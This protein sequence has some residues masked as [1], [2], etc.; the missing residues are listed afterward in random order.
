MAI[1][2]K[3]ST[4]ERFDDPSQIRTM[5][6]SHEVVYEQWDIS[7]L[8]STPKHDGESDQDHVL[9]AFSDE[10]ERISKE[11]G[12]Q[13]ADVISLWPDT[14]NLDEVLARF[15]K[16]HFHTEDEVRF[17]VS[18]RGIFAIRGLDGEM[19][20][21]EVQPGDLLAVPEGK[22]HYFEL[23]DD[24]HI[25]CIRL[26]TDQAGWVAHYIEESDSKG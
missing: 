15:D 21:V 13:S 12:Y 3:Q 6:E 2:T 8:A 26:F 7:R 17:V 9:R 24:R 5:L 25:Q 18:G 23:C 19:Y 11:R 1:V 4:G 10:V 14:P 16:E 20:D 22:H